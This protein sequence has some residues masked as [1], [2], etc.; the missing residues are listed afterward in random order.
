MTYKT[1]FCGTPDFAVKSLR[2]LISSSNFELQAV[3]TQPDKKVGRTQ[4]I[5]ESAVKIEAKKDNITILQP[6]KIYLLEDK[7]KNLN[8]DIIVVVAYG[9]IIPKSILDIP[10]YGCVN[11]HAS[12]LPKYRGATPIQSTI[13]NGDEETGLTI[14]KIDE[15]LDSGDIIAQTKIKIANSDNSETLFN[16]LAAQSGEFLIN[17]LQ[18]YI[19]GKLKPIPQDNNQVTFC[20]KIEREDGKISFKDETSTGIHQKLKAFTPWPGIFTKFNNK[21]LKILD[22]ITIKENFSKIKGQTKLN[23]TNQIAIQCK[24]GTVILKKVQVEGKK[25]ID[26]EEFIKGYPEIS[27]YTF[28]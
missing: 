21:R 18:K 20:K 15:K 7:I 4:E 25:P 24:E 28:E 1:I 10:K 3:I 23:N 27:N 19:K 6:E 16:K 12:L 14:I 9:Q 5:K 8:P 17:S 11:L 13:L 22:F 26:I 2:A